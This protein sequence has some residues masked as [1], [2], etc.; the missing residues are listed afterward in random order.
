MW[1]VSDAGQWFA[2]VPIAERRRL[3][4][5]AEVKLTNPPRSA[6]WGRA[7]PLHSI[8][9]IRSGVNLWPALQDGENSAVFKFCEMMR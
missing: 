8:P 7:K 9:A 3:R 6:K 5:V 4:A 1:R 2:H